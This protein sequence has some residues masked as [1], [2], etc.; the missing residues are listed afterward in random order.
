MTGIML[1]AVGFRFYDI[2]N[3]PPGLY[4]DEATNGVNALEALEQKDWKVFYPENNGRE[5]LFINIQ[6]LSL[7]IFGV[8]PWA[9]RAV[10][11]LF[12][13]LTVIGLFFVARLLWSA[14][15]A[16]LASYLMAVS[17]W[18][19]NFSRIGF[20]AVMLPF[21][22]VWTFYFL[23]R[24]LLQKKYWLIFPAGLIYGL[25]FHTYISWRLS[26]LLLIGLFILLLTEKSFTK[27]FLIRSAAVF[28]VGLMLTAAP[29]IWY[30]LNNQADFMGRAAQVSIFNSSS[31]IRSLGLS[32]A[33]TLGMFNIAGDFNWR[34]NLAG[35]P[36]L[37]WPLGI[38]FLIGLM[39][40]F[41]NP[42]A[43]PYKLKAVGY[44]LFLWWLVMLLPGF[45]AP[46][47]APHALRALGAMPA[48]FILSALG[49]DFAYQKIQN[50]FNRALLNPNYD[51]WFTQLR[52]IQKEVALLA[53]ALL[54]LVG[55]WE[56][57]TYFVSWA[58][59]VNTRGAFEQ[60][61]T[62][63]A[64]YLKN[65]SSD[66]EKYVVVNEGGV[67]VKGLPIQ[68]QPIIFLNFDR[69]HEIIFLKENELDQLPSDP[70]QAV[71]VPTLATDG[72]VAALNQKYPSH[73]LHG[74]G[75]FKALKMN[76]TPPQAAGYRGGFSLQGVGSA[77]NILKALHPRPSTSSG[78]GI[79]GGKIRV[80]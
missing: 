9:L 51:H 23:W 12:G 11:G 3:T 53:I 55:V 46:E 76:P 71:I 66:Y 10:S 49:L 30:Y 58:G 16:L 22:L 41:K 7:K 37:L 21:V 79:T 31:P 5:G 73:Q 65:T 70:R 77:D 29:L 36:E 52:R 72:M 34:H 44:F 56:T 28:M 63:I 1:I 38:G 24:G 6:A 33:K 60:R 20:R 68:A 78:R 64:Q 15:V 18:P 74:F 27:R 19:V 35:R 14:R 48:V 4:P 50:Y 62:D 80:E 67:M 26:P 61:L 59:N 69:R 43:N 13:T 75:T 17:F 57:R 45:L 25:G 54:L 2:A 39:F 40:I 32:T 47:G 42:K 8:Q